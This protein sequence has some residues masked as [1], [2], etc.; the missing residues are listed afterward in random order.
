MLIATG[1]E[2]KLLQPTGG[3]TLEQATGV[4][5]HGGDCQHVQE[6]TQSVQRVGHLKHPAS[7][8]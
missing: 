5:R 4:S 1:I 3:H 8:A 2:K 6:P 7:T